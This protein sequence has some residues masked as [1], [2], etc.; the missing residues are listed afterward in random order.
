MEER[1]EFDEVTLLAAF[2]MGTPGKRTFF[3]VVGQQ[4]KWVR[5]WLEK[6]QLQ[7][8]ALGVDQFLLT[9]SKERPRLPPAAKGVPLSDDVPPGLPAAEVEIDEI[10]LGYD[11][12][13]ATLSLVVHVVGPQK[14]GRALVQCR[15]TLARLEQ[16]SK[17][18]KRLCA[19]GRPRC[20]LCGGP[21]D[22][23]GHACPRSN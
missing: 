12:D 10:A 4:E 9:L 16:F 5:G 3:L 1:Y 11:H 6:E 7:S 8:L 2:A 19:A 17:Q 20:A 18:A 13:R 15:T 14:L 22:H 23:E 21:I